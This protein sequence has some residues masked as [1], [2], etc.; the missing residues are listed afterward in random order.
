MD[1]NIEIK[2][3]QTYSESY[4]T[5]VEYAY[6]T[7]ILTYYKNYDVLRGSLTVYTYKI[8]SKKIADFA[9]IQGVFFAN[10]KKVCIFARQLTRLG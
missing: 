1:Y 3:N 8:S 5:M 4:N 9:Q 7:K 2:L 10:I 6:N